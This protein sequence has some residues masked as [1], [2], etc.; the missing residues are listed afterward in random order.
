MVIEK[1]NMIIPLEENIEQL[2]S[3]IEELLKVKDLLIHSSSYKL[4][5]GKTQVSE[6][7][8]ST[9]IRSRLEHSQNISHIAQSIIGKI[10]DECATEQQKK[11]QVFLLNKKRELLYADIT[12]LSHDLGHTPFGHDGERSINRFM[13]GITDK[14]QINAIIQKRIECF[15]L[16][17]E[18]AQG[19]IGNDVTLSFEHNEQS[20]LLFYDLLH[21]GNIDLSA[22]NANKIIMAILSHSTTRVPECPNDLVA[23]VIR[24]ADKIEYRN[25][26]FEELGPFIK[27]EKFQN[28]AFTQKDSNERIDNVI[29]NLV[30][31]ALEKGK[32]DDNMS[33]LKTLKQFRKDYENLI[34]FLN[35]GTRGLL[36]SENM[37]RNRLII[38]KL[39]DY[40][41]QNPEQINPKSIPTKHYFKVT[42]IN[43]AV[44]ESVHSIYDTEESKD[45][46]NVEKVIHFIIGMDNKKIR[47]QYL[48]LVKQRI[49]TGKGVEPI[50]QEDFE[51]GR[52]FQEE[53]RIKSFESQEFN[54]S[55]QPHTKQEIRNIVTSRDSKFIREMLTSEAFTTMEATKAKI[56]EDAELDL[57]L[58]EQMEQADLARKYKREEKI[59]PTMLDGIIK[60]PQKASEEE[61]RHQAALDVKKN[62]NPQN[63]HPV[64]LGEDEDGHN[65][66]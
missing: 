26:D 1:G 61:R 6:E 57:A 22:I 37:V 2:N 33:S 20:A 23:Q 34:F 50:T 59:T 7:R 14:E 45:S 39:L 10:Y 3:E 53:E 55:T 24:L 46:T 25:M 11:S 16:D 12:S 19:H 40:Y 36:T 43:P 47:S 35:D 65:G 4:L 13:Q 31:E 62:W 28:S 38:Q 18:M 66:R 30:E 64:S 41:Y 15:G 54:T 48:K 42:P 8:D 5:H 32:I 29:H 58:C 49:V 9:F 56:K 17:Y 21:S 44:K 63:Y 51:T 52:K 27:T 60:V